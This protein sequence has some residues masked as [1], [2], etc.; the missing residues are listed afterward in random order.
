[1]LLDFNEKMIRDGRSDMCLNDTEIVDLTIQSYATLAAT[2]FLQE[3]VMYF[4]SKQPEVAD[5]IRQEMREKGILGPNDYTLEKVNSLNYLDAVVRETLRFYPVAP[6]ILFREA[7]DDHKIGNINISKGT[8]LHVPIAVLGKRPEV[9]NAEQF[10]PERYLN[11]EMDKLKGLFSIPFSAGPRDCVGQYLVMVVT[12]ILTC[13]CLKNFDLRLKGD[14]Q[15]SIF[16]KFVMKPLKPL[17]VVFEPRTAG[18]N[19][20]QARTCMLTIY[21]FNCPQNVKCMHCCQR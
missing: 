14:Y 5:K 11:G 21:L 8:L 20:M 4:I 18:M 9:P 17:P 1:M 19:V 10:R 7:Q 2:S 13:E 16:T 6:E 3:F 15:M 12:K